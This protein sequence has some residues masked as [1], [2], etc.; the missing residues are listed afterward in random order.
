MEYA[1]STD[2]YLKKT[3]I[4]IIALIGMCTIHAQND[5]IWILKYPEK[6]I[7]YTH[8]KALQTEEAIN[9]HLNSSDTLYISPNKYKLTLMT[10]YIY[11]YEYYK[12]TSPNSKQ[13]ITL[14]P[15][16][17]DKLGIYIGW[18]WI[19]L[20]WAFDINKSRNT[21]LNFSFY[22]SKIG[23]DIFYRKC[24]NGFRIRNIDGFKQSNG[25][26]IVI[27]GTPFDGIEVR[28]RGVNI[29]YIFNNKR[30]SYPA[31]YSQNTNQRI[32]CGSFILGFNYSNQTF[33]INTLKFEDAIRE[34]LSDDFKVNNVKYHDYSINFGYTYNWVFAKNCLA[35]ISATPAIGY[36][37]TSFKFEM[38]KEFLDNINFD[39]IARAALVYNNSRY[40]IG[41]SLISHTYSYRKKNLSIV[42]GFG[43]LNIYAGINL[44]RKKK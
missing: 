32:S 26:E 39:F 21:D 9:K 38:N 16:N 18:K 33:D 30:F 31:A 12:F 19:F 2:S 20:G 13:S 6:I 22:T 24:S 27:S 43:T 7:H 37:N 17:N 10:Q 44:F 5:S 15:D 40:F 34:N 11:N 41:A 28:Q 36:K 1:D 4:L 23:I 14:Q 3:I 29:Y 35:N 42:N 8:D 25:K